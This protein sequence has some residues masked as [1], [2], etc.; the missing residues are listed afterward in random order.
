MASFKYTEKF[1]HYFFKHKLFKILNNIIKISTFYL[2]I[3]LQGLMINKPCSDIKTVDY[4]SL[5][6]AVFVYHIFI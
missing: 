5:T 3:T 2:E 6:P 1:L 4:V